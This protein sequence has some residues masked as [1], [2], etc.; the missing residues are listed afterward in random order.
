MGQLAR[1]QALDGVLVAKLEF[2]RRPTRYEPPDH[3]WLF[4]SHES[5]SAI[6]LRR[7]EQWS[8]DGIQERVAGTATVLVE[9]LGPIDAVADIIRRRYGD[10][11]WVDVLGAGHTSN[12][13][14]FAR[15]VPIHIER[16]LLRAV[17]FRPELTNATGRIS[18]HELAE[19]RDQIEQH[20]IAAGCEVVTVD[21][22]RRATHRGENLVVAYAVLCRY[23][24][25][26]AAIVR[27]DGAGEVYAR[28]AEPDE[29]SG[30]VLR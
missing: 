30:R 7:S 2:E 20:L 3:I 13:D 9:C 16:D 23:G 17:F 29:A 4:A 28:L 25:E 10:S 24:D 1:S 18:A 6:T 22:R 8:D 15:W 5:W 21:P 27:L 19:L 11:G 14:L 12:A 26:I